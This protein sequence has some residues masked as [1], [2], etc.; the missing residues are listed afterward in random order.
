M[1]KLVK[2][3]G[4]VIFFYTAIIVMVWVVNYRFT[5]LNNS[6]EENK[7]AIATSEK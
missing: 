7:I 6:L 5:Y 3:Y 4:G 2:K 1:K